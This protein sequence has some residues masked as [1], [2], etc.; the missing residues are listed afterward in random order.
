MLWQRTRRYPASSDPAM[1]SRLASRE[2]NTSVGQQLRVRARVVDKRSTS[3]T[4]VASL[5]VA[6]S[7]L[8]TAGE[9][10]SPVTCLWTGED[11]WPAL[12]EVCQSASPWRRVPAGVMHSASGHRRAFLERRWRIGD[13][14]TAGRELDCP[15]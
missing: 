7:N 4:S 1:Q 9:A 11:V 15:R 3:M 12:N 2:V 10:Q 6:R 8:D 14:R 13:Q 5:A